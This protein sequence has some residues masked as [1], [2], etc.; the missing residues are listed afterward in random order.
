MNYH[1]K[2]KYSEKSVKDCWIADEAQKA[3]HVLNSDDMV[4][5]DPDDKVI[6]IRPQET[7]LC[8]T[9]EVIG[10][11]CNYNPQLLCK[12]SWG[13]SFISVCKCSSW[14]NVGFVDKWTLE[15]TNNSTSHT[16]PL[17]VGRPIGQV[18]FHSINTPEHVYDGLYNSSSWKPDDMLP[19]IYKRYS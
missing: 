11:K 14:G 2:T 15:I 10:S 16:V 12:S 6:L 18:I 13:R 19:K 7:I 8:H 9:K 3:S 4:G 5:I 17:V 1:I